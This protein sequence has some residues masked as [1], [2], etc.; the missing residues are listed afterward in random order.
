MGLWV[1]HSGRGLGPQKQNNNSNNK[2]IILHNESR[3]MAQI[4]QCRGM[5]T[6]DKQKQNSG[7]A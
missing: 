6:L 1:E 2:K 7:M 3:I 4:D 5:M